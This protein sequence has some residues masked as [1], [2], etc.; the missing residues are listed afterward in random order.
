MFTY[1]R[2]HAACVYH[3]F[4]I[5]HLVEEHEFDGDQRVV[6]CSHVSYVAIELRGNVTQLSELTLPGNEATGL[7]TILSMPLELVEP[8]GD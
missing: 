4:D 7:T 3:C 1:N 8:E 5:D 6:V 2:L